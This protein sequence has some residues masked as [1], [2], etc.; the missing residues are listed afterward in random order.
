MQ[1]SLMSRN[2]SSCFW[3]PWESTRQVSGRAAST[4]PRH[5]G[6]QVPWTGQWSGGELE[7][8]ALLVQTNAD[9]A[10]KHFPR[11]WHF[12]SWLC[13]TLGMSP[14][15]SLSSAVV[16]VSLGCCLLLWLHVDKVSGYV[17]QPSESKPNVT[18][19]TVLAH[20]LCA[21]KPY[22]H[23]LYVQRLIPHQVCCT[24]RLAFRCF[25]YFCLISLISLTSLPLPLASCSNPPN[26]AVC[27]Q[28]EGSFQSLLPQESPL[29]YPE[30]Q[31][32]PAA[33]RE[34][35]SVSPLGSAQLLCWLCSA[36]QQVSS[37]L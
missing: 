26:T 14:R 20:V 11:P 2:T 25:C 22:A 31:L 4:D 18:P 13:L 30:P 10:L 34:L 1:A 37:G 12:I 9:R 16:S 17:L 32:E 29:E 5:T 33:P 3:E 6:C 7:D 21:I 35:C 36:L 27:T 28:Q 23:L 24:I 8:P 19:V 15:R